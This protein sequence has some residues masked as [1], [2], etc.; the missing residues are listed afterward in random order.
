MDEKRLHEYVRYGCQRDAK[1]SNRAK[2]TSAISYLERTITVK[3]A[4]TI[5]DTLLLKR[6]FYCVHIG[7]CSIATSSVWVIFLLDGWCR[8]FATLRMFMHALLSF[9]GGLHA[10]TFV[11]ERDWNK[12]GT[13]NI[14]VVESYSGIWSYQLVRG[15]YFTGWLVFSWS[16]KKLFFV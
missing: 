11:K 15:F 13:K 9:K 12:M 1:L 6:I 4:M 14:C 3:W 2:C 10:Y 7:I 5:I 16:S 8:S